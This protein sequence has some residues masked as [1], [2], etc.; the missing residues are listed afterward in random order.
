MYAVESGP[1]NLGKFLT[2]KIN[3]RETL[4]KVFAQDFTEIDAVAIMTDTDNT[5]KEA[6]AYYGEIFFSKQ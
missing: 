6:A 2:Y 5:Q 1:K 3:I 4:K